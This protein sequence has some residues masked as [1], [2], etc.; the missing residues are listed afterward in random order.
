MTLFM[1]CFVKQT[2]EKGHVCHAGGRSTSA[3]HVS[4]EYFCSWTWSR[5][6]LLPL[7]A[8]LPFAGCP[9]MTDISTSRSSV[10]ITRGMLLFATD[11]SLAVL[12]YLML[13]FKT[14]ISGIYVHF[15]SKSVPFIIPASLQQWMEDWPRN[16]HQCH[17]KDWDKFLTNHHIVSCV[18]EWGWNSDSVKTQISPSIPTWLD[19]S[20]LAIKMPIAL[21][22]NHSQR[23][24]L[25]YFTGLF[26]FFFPQILNT[27]SGWMSYHP[28]MQRS[29]NTCNLTKSFWIFSVLLQMAS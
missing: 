20:V 14:N 6:Y 11:V 18:N 25:V 15:K 23:S 19:F 3:M 12:D 24:E 10:H 8:V 16:L 27:R 29:K 22:S 1:C 21:V 17:C 7:L 2:C 4:G 28:G 9:E 13:R 26:L 5:R